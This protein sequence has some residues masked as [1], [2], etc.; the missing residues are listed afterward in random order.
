MVKNEGGVGGLGA[1]KN[2]T[3]YVYGA[4][5]LRR[6]SD[7]DAA[8]DWIGGDFCFIT[9]G[10]LYADT[11]WV[12]TETITTLDTDSIIWQ[13]FSGAGSFTADETTLTLSGT[14]FS[15]KNTYVGQ[16]SITTLGTIATGTWNASTIGETRGGTGQTTY[17]TGDLLYASSSSALS[18]LTIGA[19]NYVL[20]SNSTN[21]VWTAN[22]GTGSVVRES[23]PTITSPSITTSITTGSTSFDA[24]NTTATTLNIGGAC[25]AALNLAV[26]ASATRIVNIAT[27][28][29]G[30]RTI[31][32][33]NDSTGNRTVNLLRHNSFEQ[34]YTGIPYTITVKIADSVDTNTNY[35]NVYIG[36]NATGV[37]ATDINYITIG[38]AGLSTTSLFGSFSIFNDT[39]FYVYS[40]TNIA[41]DG[42]VMTPSSSGS[43]S[44]VV[45]ITP[46][47]LTDT[48][49]FTLPNVSG[50]AITTGNLTSI[51]TTGTI[52]TG[53]W[54]GTAIGAIYGGTA[55][56][57]YATGDLLYSSATNTL[58][59][60][61]KPAATSFLQMTSAG[62]P[63]WT[64]TIPTTDGGTGLT[65]FTS[66]GLVYAS[67]TSALTTGTVFGINS[68][69]TAYRINIASAASPKTTQ[70]FKVSETAFNSSA[71]IGVYTDVLDNPPGSLG[72]AYINLTSTTGTDTL[73]TLS[74]GV[75]S[76]T[77]SG[78]TTPLSLTAVPS[79]WGS[80]VGVLYCIDDA[81]NPYIL[82]GDDG[83]NNATS[84]KITDTS[85]TM[86][87]QATTLKINT[88]TPASGKVLTCSD[89]NGTV[90]WET[91]ASGAD[92]L[93]FA[94]GII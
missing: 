79:L 67:S 22:T 14:Q 12:Q 16:T 81:V 35:A 42:I 83:T 1:S 58:S 17:A 50:T 74:S 38:T 15:I 3:Y 4:R 85:S 10:T 33:A 41:R 69:A 6:T 19:N 76:V 51:T 29:A 53:T 40:S 39:G 52:G 60:L 5:E 84:I 48:R 24:F 13:Q 68:T 61:A 82:F 36:A 63:S 64:D 86:V 93:L 34:D 71:A 56:T 62:V 20:T 49:T 37:A 2:G 78:G 92:Y 23:S 46:A 75:G 11:G 21:P 94:M 28:A 43:S 26:A 7:G 80:S 18:K 57:S 47:S 54:Q 44:Y 31:N 30:N 66:G 25:S 55:Q 88:S 59:K 89:S 91:A 90:S 8:S 27:G 45:S 87:V 65:S 32:I 9:S 77:F 70:E 72:Q 73:I